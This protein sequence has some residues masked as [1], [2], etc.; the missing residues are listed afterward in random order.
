MSSSRLTTP[1]ASNEQGGRR[2]VAV[3][4]SVDGGMKAGAVDKLVFDRWG[5]GWIVKRHGFV[6]QAT[7]AR[8]S[9]ARQHQRR[10]CK[11]HRWRD[12]SFQAGPEHPEVASVEYQVTPMSGGRSPDIAARTLISPG[13]KLGGYLYRVR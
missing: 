3:A 9:L 12:V 4:K 11:G 10:W 7:V 6:P 13:V 1:A 2:Q 5:V 8:R